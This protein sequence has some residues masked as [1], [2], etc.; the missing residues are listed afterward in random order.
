MVLLLL[1]YM[2]FDHTLPIHQLKENAHS[3]YSIILH[4]IIRHHILEYM[5][6]NNEFIQLKTKLDYYLPTFMLTLIIPIR[7]NLSNIPLNNNLKIRRTNLL[8]I[9]IMIHS[10]F[11]ITIDNILTEVTDCLVCNL[12]FTSTLFY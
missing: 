6:M 3:D 10:L 7:M 11:S 5:K 12:T 1:C 8:T 2:V 4:F 9:V